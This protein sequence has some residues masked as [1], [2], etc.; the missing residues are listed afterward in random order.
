MYDFVV[1]S[2][3]A[4]IALQPDRPILWHA[5][6]VIANT[7]SWSVHVLLGKGQDLTVAQKVSVIRL[8]VALA[9]RGKF[10]PGNVYGHCE[11]PRDT[12][13]AKPS[14]IYTVQPG[15]SACPERVLHTHLVQYR[16]KTDAESLWVLWGT[17]VPLAPEQ[18]GWSIPQAWLNE[19]GRWGQALTPEYYPPNSPYSVSMQV[20]E[21]GVAIYN[22]TTKAVRFAAW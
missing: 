7:T 21:R 4:V 3:G 2:D 18:R 16:A 15:Q 13:A 5:G 19:G 14:A 9:Q 20:F 17:T 11:W 12:G 22:G 1:L 10:P 6:N 8:F